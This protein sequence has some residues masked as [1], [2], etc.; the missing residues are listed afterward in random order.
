M[1]CEG[2]DRSAFLGPRQA[3]SSGNQDRILLGTGLG[4]SILPT[5]WARG[6]T[7]QSHFTQAEMQDAGLFGDD[8]DAVAEALD[9][10]MSGNVHPV[11]EESD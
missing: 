10:L 3:S 7:S 11:A 6:G 1:A 4:H 8:L 2:V 9:S 5:G